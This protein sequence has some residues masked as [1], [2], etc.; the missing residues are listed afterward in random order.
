MKAFVVVA[1]K[2]RPKE[3]YTLLNY[4]E[5][6][7]FP[8]EKIVIVGSEASDVDGLETHPLAAQQ[9]V[10]IKISEA[11]S[12][13]QRNVGLDEVSVLTNNIVAKDWFAV[14]FD[15]DFRPSANWIENSASLFTAEENAVGVGGKVLADGAVKGAPLTESDAIYYLNYRVP[16]EPHPWSGNLNRVTRGLYGCNMA[17]RGTFARTER[18]DENL[19]LYGWQE[20]VDY[21]IR[22]MSYGQ[23]YYVASCEGVHMGVTGGRTSGVRFGYSQIANPIYLVRKGTMSKRYA[24]KLMFK[25]FSSNVF[26]TIMF[27]RRKGCLERL[28][29]N[30]KAIFDLTLNQCNP[31]NITKI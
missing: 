28:I 9:K 6:Q 29:G 27:K 4:L 13:V 5:A 14:I 7:T 12:C 21:T 2:G 18:F 1:T 30:F 23:L 11:G 24:C 8:I 19:P 22:A 17:I 31:A 10:T 20:D 16:A 25:N 26:Y 15:D 3:T